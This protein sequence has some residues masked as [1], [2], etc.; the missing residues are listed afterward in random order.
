MFPQPAIVYQ[1]L[2]SVRRT[3]GCC[4]GVTDT[5]LV[6]PRCDVQ[7]GM[8]DPP[9]LLVVCCPPKNRIPCGTSRAATNIA[10]GTGAELAT[11][12]VH[13]LRTSNEGVDHTMV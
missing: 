11:Y 3:W 10:S 1:T 7:G 12:V 13:P 2:V 9:Q 8:D 5:S 6:Q 4:D